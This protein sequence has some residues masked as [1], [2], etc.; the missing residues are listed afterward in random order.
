MS[1]SSKKG[2]WVEE[3]HEH[4]HPSG[5]RYRVLGRSRTKYA[6]LP[7]SLSGLPYMS[8]EGGDRS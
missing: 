3:R 5:T 6:T 7:A 4:V 2:P 8:V 1:R